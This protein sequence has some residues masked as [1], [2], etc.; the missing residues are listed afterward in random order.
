MGE[1]AVAGGSLSAGWE[2]P[3][4]STTG[5]RSR[6]INTHTGN[7]SRRKCLLEN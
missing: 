4:L 7:C 5:W 1:L 6:A 2:M 3:C